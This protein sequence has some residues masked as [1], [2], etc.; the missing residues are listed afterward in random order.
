MNSIGIV[1]RLLL[2]T[3]LGIAGCQIERS[4]AAAGPP[5]DAPAPTQAKGVTETESS[6]LSL[7]DNLSQS[8]GWR[9]HTS[10]PTPRSE[11]PAAEWAGLIYVPGGYGGG[12]VTEAT[13]E[14]YDPVSDAWAS[15]TPMP[16][17]RHHLM[18]TAHQGK[19]YAFGGGRSLQDRRPTN[20]A[21][22]YDPAANAWD[23]LASMP[24]RRIAGV[25]VSLG[26]YIYIVG[27]RGATGDL[28]RYDPVADA[29]SSLA[30]LGQL[31]EHLAAV[32]IDGKIYALAGR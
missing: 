24:E 13:F 10:M 19:I 20:T 22:V 17:G 5:G 2:L 1:A 15:L 26:D 12:F 7:V 21:W 29:W 6:F 27:G 30:S 28:L 4:L 3:C 16:E 23:E 8:A 9:Q 32:T 18:A 25:A 31:R 11:M 14:V